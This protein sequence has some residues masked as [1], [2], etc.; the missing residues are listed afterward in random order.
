MAKKIILLSIGSTILLGLLFAYSFTGIKAYQDL[1]LNRNLILKDPHIFS[2]EIVQNMDFFWGS[3]QAYSYGGIW[4][5]GKIWV[6]GR[7]G[8]S[9]FATNNDTSYKLNDSC[10][11]DGLDHTADNFD[12]LVSGYDNGGHIWIRYQV[13]GG[14]TKVAREVFYYGRSR[15]FGIANLETV[16]DL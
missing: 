9:Y 1:I 14:K 4:A 10:L 12:K 2:N 5:G 8:L 11:G 7:K 13:I 6:W 15:P 16:C 3:D